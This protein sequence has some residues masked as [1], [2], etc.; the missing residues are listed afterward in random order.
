MVTIRLTRKGVKNQPFFHVMV[1]DKRR[2]Q[3]G[4]ALE[5]VGFFNPVARGGETRLRLDL[6]RIEYWQSQG[7]ELSDR[8][9]FLVTS[10]RKA[11]GVN[12]GATAEAGQSAAA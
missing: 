2:R 12:N 9:K 6:P 10:H 3:G 1:T 11:Q 7:A 4:A 5:Q 8:V